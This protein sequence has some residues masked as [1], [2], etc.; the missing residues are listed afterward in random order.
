MKPFAKSAT[1]TLLMFVALFPNAHAQESR[2]TIAGE[3]TDASGAARTFSP[4]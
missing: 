1:V 3:V 2:G 4:L